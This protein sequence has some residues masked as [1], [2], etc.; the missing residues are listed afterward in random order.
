M[1]AVHVHLLSISVTPIWWEKK[2]QDEYVSNHKE[3]I[4][5]SDTKSSTVVVS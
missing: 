1:T 2:K 3:T 4:N 5:K